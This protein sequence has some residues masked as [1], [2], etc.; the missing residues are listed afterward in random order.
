MSPEGKGQREVLGLCFQGVE[1]RG[2]SFGTKNTNIGLKMEILGSRPSSPTHCVTL[3]K[4]FH[5]NFLLGEMEVVTPL[6]IV[7]RI[8]WHI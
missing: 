7:K 5:Q 3:G 6:K 4:S 8:I 1:L 2:D